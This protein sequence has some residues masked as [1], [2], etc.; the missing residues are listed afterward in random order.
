MKRKTKRQEEIEQAY[1]DAYLLWKIISDE[2]FT[3]AFCK[4]I[5]DIGQMTRKML[6]TL[7]GEENA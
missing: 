4:D 3:K 7:Q 1:L 5:E 6:R 2:R